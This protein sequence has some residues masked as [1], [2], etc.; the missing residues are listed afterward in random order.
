[1]VLVAAAGYGKTSALEA[2]RPADG[3][4]V[5]A[6]EL[7]DG[8]LPYAP[9]LGVDDLDVL[10]PG[11]QHALLQRLAGLPAHVGLALA[12]R[13]VVPLD[14]L[15]GQVQQRG[16]RHLALDDYGIATVLAEE[17]GVLDPDAAVA[18]RRLTAGWPAM[19]HFA[20]DLIAYHPDVDVADALSRPGSPAA[21]WVRSTVVAGL[22]ES[23]RTALGLM[24]DLGP[25]TPGLRELLTRQTCLRDIDETVDLLH[26]V[27]ILRA[28][29]R[30][31]IVPLLTPV[32]V[33][34]AVLQRSQ[35]RPGSDPALQ[36]AAAACYQAEGLPYQAAQACVRAGDAAALGDLIVQDGPRMLWQG[37]A[38]GVVELFAQC[39]QLLT[40]PQAQRIL[41]EAH[42]MA[43]DNAAAMRAFE[44]LVEAAGEQGWDT[45]LASQVAMVHYARGDSERALAFLARGDSA[46]TTDEHAIE[47]LAARVHVLATRGNSRQAQSVAAQALAAAERD[48]RPR[49]L[50][51]AHTAVAR[52][53]VGSRKDAH[54]ELALRAAAQAGDVLIAV[55]ALVNQSGRLLCAARYAEARA[56]SS[57]A[58]RLAELGSPPARYAVAL[59]NLGVALLRVGEFD[60]A[61][62]QLQRAI[63]IFG[64]LGP[65]R[66]SMGLIG[67][68]HIHH[69]LGQHEPART[70]YLEAIALS[71]ATG[72][73]QV[74]VRA[75]AG[76]GRLQAASDPDAAWANAEHAAR[77]A[78]EGLRP[79][80]LVGL[81]W[82][83]L[84]RGDRERAKAWADEAVASG[85]AVQASDPLAE[86][87]ELSAEC[88]ASENPARARHALAEAWGIWR[89]GGA[90]VCAARTEVLLGRLADADGTAR[91]KAREASRRLTRMGILQVHGRSV[92]DESGT[93]HVTVNVLGGFSVTVGAEPV[94]LPAWRSRQ[95]R[96][97]LK[98]LA[99]RRGRPAT[100]AFLCEL[101]WP[102]D[103]P[104]KT[105]HRL[106]VLLTTVRGVLDPA[107]SWPPDYYIAADPSGVWLD[108][109]HVALDADLLLHDA[110]LAAQ[111]MD[112]GD[113]DRAR[114]ILTDIDRRYR[115]P[116]F[117]DDP[118]EEWADGFREQVRASWAR[119]MRRLASL[120]SRAGR[121]SDAQTLLVRLLA[122][123]PYDALVHQL[124][125]RNLVRGGRHGEARRAFTRWRQ[126]MA[127]ID[128]PEPSGDIL[129]PVLTRR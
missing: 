76:L 106:S 79:F 70:A 103:D 53:S 22:P 20:G 97:L 31:G 18:V 85:R 92:A 26:S 29:Q 10:T 48:G 66:S 102:G 117:E 112:A 108:L 118:F 78:T 21:E 80:A 43:G 74:L 113:L 41:A 36:S 23:A 116:A 89:D 38:S 73:L 59:H 95:A 91:S 3:V 19:V 123:D 47:W 57:E 127:S 96:S 33:V 122:E 72:E 8:P 54:H 2:D 104:A 13:S 126:A 34:G 52:A 35:L 55:H 129:A 37:Y 65:G 128:A 64:R 88:D 105:G 98:V 50:A 93:Q 87:L 68:A 44:P 83:A 120:H 32:P 101:L 7:L 77:I 45:A 56:V 5:R 24:A 90:A 1:M 69:E 46:A 25:V 16:P 11:Q 58:V 28:E 86:A 121:H 4:L 9:W 6:G 17:Y 84:A 75:L 99:A 124:L 62:W 115:G 82:V 67:I 81:G 63:T 30:L 100:R 114:E 14:A 60:Q 107:R 27:G 71:T 94:P 111:L 61:K 49:A 15:R 39:P 110:D 119:S 42:R 12:S 109:R 40:S 51:A 125:V